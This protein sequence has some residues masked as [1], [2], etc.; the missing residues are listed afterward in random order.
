VRFVSDGDDDT[1]AVLSDDQAAAA[2]T[3]S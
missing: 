1:D 2:A 3:R